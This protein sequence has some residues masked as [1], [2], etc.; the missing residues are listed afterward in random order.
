MRYGN[1]PQ[2][3]HPPQDFTLDPAAPKPTTDQ[4][5]EWSCQGARIRLERVK[6]HPD[7]HIFTSD[8]RVL[9]R[10]PGND[11]R[12][13]LAAPPMLTELADFLKED[14]R[15]IEEEYPFRLL[16]RRT[17]NI[18]NSFGRQI[19]KLA[20]DGINPAYM[21]PADLTRLNIA[22]GDC[23]TIH[24][25]YGEIQAIIATEPT[26]KTGMI[27]MVRGYGANPGSDD[28]RRT[29]GNT[30]RLI[31]VED[32]YDPVTGLL[33]MGGIPVQVLTHRVDS[34]IE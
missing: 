34:R 3:E 16:P 26:L 25:P 13:D 12:L 10:A 28:P 21:H 11:D 8:Q 27:S 9:P 22:E 19:T 18:L 32:R 31:S 2:A 30:G 33:R 1:G 20:G 5:I 15:I 24:S 17:N 6:Q 14:N 4:I 29:G 7:G 23:V